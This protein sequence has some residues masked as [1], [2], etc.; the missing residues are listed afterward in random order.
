MTQTKKIVMF[1]VVGLALLVLP[2]FLQ[3]FGNAW[4]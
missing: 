1:F 4:A 2:L 3:L